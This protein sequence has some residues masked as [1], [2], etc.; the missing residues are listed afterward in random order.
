MKV[1]VAAAC[2]WLLSQFFLTIVVAKYE[3]I[4]I[5]L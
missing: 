1:Y 2:D 3:Q 5:N 4:W